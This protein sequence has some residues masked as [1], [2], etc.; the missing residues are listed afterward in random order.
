MFND[1]SEGASCMEEEQRLRHDRL[2]TC[3][4]LEEKSLKGI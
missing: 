4:H 1:R 3:R 2:A